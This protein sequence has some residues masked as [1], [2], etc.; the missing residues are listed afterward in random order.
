[1]KEAKLEIGDLVFAFAY[2]GEVNSALIGVVVRIS[3]PSDYSLTSE[4]VTVFTPN[5]FERV[6]KESCKIISKRK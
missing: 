2:R 5:G 4:E 6:R 3:P 1:M